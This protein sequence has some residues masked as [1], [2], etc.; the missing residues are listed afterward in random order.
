MFTPIQQII[1]DVLTKYGLTEENYALYDIWEKQLGR[2][3]KNIKLV[4]VKDKYILV[5]VQSSTY[6]HELHLRE[7]E[8]LKKINGYFGKDVYT[9]IKRITGEDSEK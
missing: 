9:K 1:K 2:L 8:I 4:G 7:K 6:A 5:K 3:A